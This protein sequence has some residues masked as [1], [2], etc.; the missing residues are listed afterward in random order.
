MQQLVL[1][2]RID[3]Y[4]EIRSMIGPDRAGA[5]QRQVLN[6]VRA[7]CRS[8][9]KVSV[10]HDDECGAIAWVSDPDNGALLAERI[11]ERV[12]SRVFN[13]GAG[14][15]FGL[16]CSIGF[17]AHPSVE[18]DPDEVIWKQTVRLARS[19]VDDASRWSDDAWLG[20]LDG[21]GP[22]TSIST[23][24]D[25]VRQAGRPTRKAATPSRQNRFWTV[26]GGLPDRRQGGNE[27]RAKTTR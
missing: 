1:M 20:Y 9:D 10:C 17:S 4:R 5:I 18:S 26:G 21:D 11:Q 16:T 24:D 19:A 2:I 23:G 13:A 15:E 25:Q 3:H 8:S 6:V 7:A 27:P 14:F 12:R 22:P